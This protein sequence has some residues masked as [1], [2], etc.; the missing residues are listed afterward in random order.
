[1]PKA[2]LKR[3]T[4]YFSTLFVWGSI[5]LPR[6]VSIATAWARQIFIHFLM[7]WELDWK[8]GGTGDGQRYFQLSHVSLGDQRIFMHEIPPRTLTTFQK[9]I[10]HR[11]LACAAL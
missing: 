4:I 1:V 3:H 7:S 11:R 2:L 10:K 5:D 8:A 9:S 6:F